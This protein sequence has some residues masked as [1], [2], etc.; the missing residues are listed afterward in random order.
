MRMFID[1][2]GTFVPWTGWGV[3]CSLALPHKHCHCQFERSFG[4][5]IR[6]T[7]WRPSR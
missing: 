1:E 7:S 3:V 6:F 5:D 4:F 2:G